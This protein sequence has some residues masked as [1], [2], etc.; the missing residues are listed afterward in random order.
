MAIS[1]GAVGINHDMLS[2][3]E[4]ITSRELASPSL[5][6]EIEEIITGNDI[7]E[8]DR[9]QSLLDSCTILDFTKSDKMEDVFHEVSRRFAGR[10]GNMNEKQIYQ[11]FMEREKSSSTA[12]QAFFALPHVVVEGKQIFEMIMVRSP[13]GIKFMQHETKIHTMFFLAGSLDQRHFHLVVIAALAR[14]VRDQGFED[15][16][17]QAASPD[18][19]RQLIQG[20]QA[21]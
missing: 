19:L 20:L 5:Q 21:K 9:L 16:W 7:K 10:L 8:K 11:K 3:V 15:A 1:H 4:R 18:G 2:M 12:I 17:L 14:M 6:K 13:A